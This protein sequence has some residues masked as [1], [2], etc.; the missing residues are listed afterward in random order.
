MTRRTLTSDE[1]L[2][3]RRRTPAGSPPRGARSR[4]PRSSASRCED[5]PVA[6][7]IVEVRFAAG[8]HEHYLV[9]LGEDDE[10]V[11][12]FERPEV[13]ARLA[14]ARRR[15]RGGGPRPVVRRRAVE[16]LRR[17]RRAARAQALPPA[18]GRP[19]PR[20]RDPPRPRRDG[21]SRTRPGSRARSRRTGPPLETALASVTALVP[22]R[23]RRL[24][25]DARLARRRRVVAPRARVAARRGDRRAARRARGATTRTRRSRPEEPS[26]ESLGLLA[27]AIDEEI[28]TTF[29]TLPEDDALGAV[30]HRVRGHPRPRPGARGRGARRGSRSARTATTTSA[31]CSGRPTA[32]GS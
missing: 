30:A 28:A 5:G 2:G 16:Q 15:A 12:A 23:R 7:A 24:G 13:A 8:T 19:E 29:S 26:A 14:V 25:A 1:L 32:T 20:A 27:A 3:A 18:R 11:D 31:R 21:G 4:A 17:A 6:L 9:A 10:P 22:S